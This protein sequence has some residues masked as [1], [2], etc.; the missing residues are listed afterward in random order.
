[1]TTWTIV[2]LIAAAALMA[3]EVM[4]PSFGM[5][6]L[7]AATS[8]V[9]AVVLAFKQSAADGFLV[10][11]IGLL[12]LPASFVLGLRL[13]KR[14]RFGRKTVLEGPAAGSIQRGFSEGMGALI[15]KSGVATT[16]LRPTGRA[17]FAGLRLDV[18]SATDFVSKDTPIRIVGVDGTRIV[19]EPAP[20]ITERK[21]DP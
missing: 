7:L 17:D 16:D 14:T 19:V 8:Y 9:F 4:I 20:A 1:M 2:L 5:L 10:A 11:G 21:G 15:G 6:G 13:M 18:T 3:L 12:V